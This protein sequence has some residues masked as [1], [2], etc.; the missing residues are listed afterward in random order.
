MVIFILNL[1]F[2]NL[3]TLCLNGAKSVQITHWQAVPFLKF[4]IHFLETLIYS[5]LLSAHDKP[6]WNNNCTWAPFADS[7]LYGSTDWG[8]L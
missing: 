1:L 6:A 7:A 3:N 5:L 2:S 4:P 8:N